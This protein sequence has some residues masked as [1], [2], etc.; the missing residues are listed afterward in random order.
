MIIAI[1]GPAGAGKST[2]CRILAQRLNFLYLDTGA[3]YRALAWGL[4]QRKD[5]LPDDQ[6][7]Q[8]LPQVPLQFSIKEGRL[9]ILYSGKEIADQIRSPEISDEASR[10]SR[11]EPVRSFLLEWQRKLARQ[12]DI[13]AEGR[14]TATVVFPDAEMKIFLTADLKTRIKRRRSEYI[15]KGMD[16]PYEELETRIRERDEADANRALAPMKPAERATILDTSHLDIVQVV[17]RLIEEVQKTQSGSK[18]IDIGKS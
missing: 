13:V 15:Q 17:E 5:R 16:I 6:I 10:V 1:D 4:L 12:G 2:V 11:L 14:D 9:E 3:M 18:G 7:A 8:W